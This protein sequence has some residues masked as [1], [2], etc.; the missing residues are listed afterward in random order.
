MDIAAVEI[1]PTRELIHLFYRG[2]ANGSAQKRASAKREKTMP[3]GHET[4]L[5]LVDGDRFSYREEA[6]CSKT[7]ASRWRSA[8]TAAALGSVE[9]EADTA[10]PRVYEC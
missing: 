9:I 1:S 6:G 4:R 8:W 2:A 3:V 7:V 10:G 5:T